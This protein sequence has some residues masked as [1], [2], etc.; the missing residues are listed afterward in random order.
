M[1][2]SSLKAARGTPLLS[3]TTVTRLD[4]REGRLPGTGLVVRR[5]WMLLRT[6]KK[7]WT[8]GSSH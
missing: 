7:C 1:R 3:L 2:P 8:I 6:S 4:L 5:R